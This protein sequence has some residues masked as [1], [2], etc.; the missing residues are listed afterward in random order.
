MVVVGL[1]VRLEEK[2][3]TSSLVRTQPVRLMATMREGCAP[4]VVSS[5]GQ[6]NR[7]ALRTHV[8]HG[9]GFQRVLEI[10]EVCAKEL[11]DNGL[12]GRRITSG[13]PR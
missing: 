6:P 11:D 5:G 3:A 9:L 2:C 7:S 13:G 8:Y 10:E 4:C 1:P 12:S